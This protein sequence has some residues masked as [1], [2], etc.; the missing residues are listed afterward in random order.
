MSD[1]VATLLHTDYIYAGICATGSTVT[2]T[3]SFMDNIA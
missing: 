1:T 3:V 2:V